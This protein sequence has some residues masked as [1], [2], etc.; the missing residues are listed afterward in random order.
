[1]DPKF[2]I[3]LPG[4]G[5][6]DELLVYLTEIDNT[7]VPSLSSRVNLREW[8]KKLID[9]AT[10][11]IYRDNGK[12]VACVADYVNKAPLYSFGTHLSCKHEYADF[13]LG[14]QLI[15]KA[16]KY[17]REYGSAGKTGKIRESYTALV[18]YYLK[19]GFKIVNK[20]FFPN[21][22]V[23]ELEIKIDF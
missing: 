14:P 10:L 22:D 6:Y 2:E 16:L 23:V 18:N 8:T 5:N 11:F 20:S 9:H 12:I 19:Q 4:K 1:M 17:E 7:H 13:L 3:I 21:S 15:R